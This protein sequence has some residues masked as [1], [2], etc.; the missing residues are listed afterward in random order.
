MTSLK[1]SQNIIIPRILWTGH[2]YRLKDINLSYFKS[3]KKTYL[4]MMINLRVSSVIPFLCNDSLKGYQLEI[5][6]I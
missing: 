4:G 3:I 5:H 2:E 1:I 6:F